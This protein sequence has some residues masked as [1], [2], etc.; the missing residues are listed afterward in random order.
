MPWWRSFT[1][2]VF[3]TVDS[4]HIYLRH[5]M[6]ERVIDERGIATTSP[7]LQ[8]FFGAYQPLVEH[9]ALAC[10]AALNR[11]SKSESFFIDHLTWAMAALLVE[12]HG[13]GWI[14]PSIVHYPG[15]TDRQLNRAEEYMLDHI[16]GDLGVED[17]SGC[18][19]LKPCLFR[20]AIQ[21]S[22]RLFAPSL[23]SL[24]QGQTS[25]R[26]FTQ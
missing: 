16:D 4:A 5:D 6:I 23:P 9:L 19:W 17:L 12:T 7:P 2:R 26:T 21:A 18:R 8:P 20:S 22:H 15:L 25:K 13:R 10:V 1:V 24:S 11:P 3:D 14:V